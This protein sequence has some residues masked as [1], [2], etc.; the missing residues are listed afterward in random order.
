MK[1]K[2]RRTRNKPDANK[3]NSQYGNED[4]IMEISTTEQVP[5]AQVLTN[6]FGEANE[7]LEV[8]A[9][10]LTSNG[11]ESSKD[12]ASL[13]RTSRAE[14]RRREIERKR[15]EKREL[16]RLKREEEE[17]KANLQVRTIVHALRILLASYPGS[18]Y[19]PPPSLSLS[20]A[21]TEA[22]EPGGISH[23]P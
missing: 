12:S 8:T 11:E 22:N 3:Q 4:S 9:V 19:L 20:C 2:R 23:Y 18:T 10:Q 7:N 6:S 16:E 17:R 14:E 13:Q 1:S 5:D 21:S 15:A